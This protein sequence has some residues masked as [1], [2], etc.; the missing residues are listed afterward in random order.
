MAGSE[1]I[2]KSCA[3][4]FYIYNQKRKYLNNQ[5]YDTH[6]TVTST[7]VTCTSTHIRAY[8]RTHTHTHTHTHTRFTH[9]CVHIRTV[10]YKFHLQQNVRYNFFNFWHYR[11]AKITILPKKL[12]EAYNVEI[13][14]DFFSNE[15]FILSN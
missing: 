15:K 4:F 5:T 14:M 7:H 10:I 9:A 1:K 8:S 11:P 13:C 12:R 3:N 2:K 6:I